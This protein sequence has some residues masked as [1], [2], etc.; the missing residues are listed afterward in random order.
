M[1]GVASTYAE[2]NHPNTLSPSSITPCWA[3]CW[4]YLAPLVHFTDFSPRSKKRRMIFC[5]E[6]DANDVQLKITSIKR[7]QKGIARNVTGGMKAVIMTDTFQ[8][9]ILM[10]SL[11]LIMILGQI[12]V[13]SVYDVFDI[14]SE[15]GRIELTKAF[16][17]DSGDRGV[18]YWVPMFCSNQASI[19]KYLSVKTTKQVRM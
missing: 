3:S 7:Q 15:S 13:G 18:A 2:T 6:A 10:I 1:P 11:I 5:S 4:W 14:V 16:D 12:L 17:M 9:A 19:Q 8:A